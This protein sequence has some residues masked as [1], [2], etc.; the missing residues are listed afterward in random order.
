[1]SDW[2][3]VIGL[4]I[5]TQLS[6]KSKIFSASSSSGVESEKSEAEVSLFDGCEMDVCKL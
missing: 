2:E 5:H 3:T 6:T 4:E 1:M